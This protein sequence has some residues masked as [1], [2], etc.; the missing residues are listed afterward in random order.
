MIKMPIGGIL[1]DSELTMIEC[2]GLPDRPGMA[3]KLLSHLGENE[4]NLKFIAECTDLEGYGNL[5][6]CLEGADASIALNMMKNI[7]SDGKPK[8]ILRKDG[9]TALTIYGPHFRDKPAISGMICS[10]LGQA[11]INILGISTSISSVCC[12]VWDEEFPRAYKNLIR[13]FSLP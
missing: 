9:V 4:I 11:D 1:R 8:K 3:G 7:H 13:I 6:F 5:S 2:L 10:V 12:I